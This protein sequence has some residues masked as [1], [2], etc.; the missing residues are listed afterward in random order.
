[1]K[2]K[3]VQFREAVRIVGHGASTHNTFIN[4]ERL[5]IEL[6]DYK[7][8]NISTKDDA[9]KLL[10]IIPFS[11]CAFCYPSESDIS[12]P[13]EDAVQKI[14]DGEQTDDPTTRFAVPVKKTVGK[15]LKHGSNEGA[16]T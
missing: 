12:E 15:K 16:T 9:P 8:F 1:M 5:D 10:V 13:L 4:S 7:Y 14:E 11:N 2:I 3:Y 6:I